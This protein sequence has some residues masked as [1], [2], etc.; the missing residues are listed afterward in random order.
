MTESPR[1]QVQLS[2]FEKDGIN[3]AQILASSS[4]CIRECAS[5]SHHDGTRCSSDVNPTVFIAAINAHT[6]MDAPAEQHTKKSLLSVDLHA[7]TLTSEPAFGVS[8]FQHRNCHN[9]HPK[10]HDAIRP[11]TPTYYSTG[12]TVKAEVCNYCEGR[13]LQTKRDSSRVTQQ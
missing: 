3:C 7:D 5:S 8:I 2:H 6:L 11:I 4:S 10:H 13:S 12:Y 9:H 1:S